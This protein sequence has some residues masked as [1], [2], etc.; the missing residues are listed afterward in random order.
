MVVLLPVDVEIVLLMGCFK[1]DLHRELCIVGWFVVG[2]CD[3]NVQKSEHRQHDV[4]S[5]I[6]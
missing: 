3:S 1:T 2:A 5:V 6:V 4:I